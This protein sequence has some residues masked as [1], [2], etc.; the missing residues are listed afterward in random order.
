MISERSKLIDALSALY[1]TVNATFGAGGAVLDGNL[2][3]VKSF[4][5]PG[6]G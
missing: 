2:N 1:A 6:G 5:K 3:A 4:P